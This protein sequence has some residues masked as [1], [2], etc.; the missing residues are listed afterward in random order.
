MMPLQ[1]PPLVPLDAEPEP[2]ALFAI[3]SWS[4]SSFDSRSIMEMPRRCG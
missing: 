3:Q 1:V 2:Q 4:L